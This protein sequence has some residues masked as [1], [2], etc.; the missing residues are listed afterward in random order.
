MDEKKSKPTD[1]PEFKSALRTGLIVIG[2]AVIV[3]V[4]S[5]VFGGA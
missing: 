1:S 5:I 2:V 3:V 4:I